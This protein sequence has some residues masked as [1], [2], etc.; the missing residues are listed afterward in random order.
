MYLNYL[1]YFDHKDDSYS[2]K[3]MRKIKFFTH[4]ILRTLPMQFCAP[5][6]FTLH[7]YLHMLWCTY[8][9]KINWLCYSTNFLPSQTYLLMLQT[10]DSK[11]MNYWYKTYKLLIQNLQTTNPFGYKLQILNL[12]T[13]NPFYYKLQI[14][15]L[16]T[17]NPFCYKLQILNLATNYQSFLLQTPDSKITN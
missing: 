9:H 15:N 3:W 16:R 7:Y 11:I 17:T 1:L 2:R 5:F 13:T 8:A 12:R 4:T 10:P 14:L 6:L